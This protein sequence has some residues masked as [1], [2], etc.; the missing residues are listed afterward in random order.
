MSGTRITVIDCIMG[1]GK[2]SYAI[3]YVNS[4]PE[5]SF[6][7]CTPFLDEVQRIKEQC[8]NA[9]FYDPTCYNGRKIDD[10]NRLLMEGKNIVLTH[11]TFA[12]ADED[13]LEYISNTDYVLIMDETLNILENF[14]NVCSDSKQTVTKADIRML[15]DSGCIS[16]DDYGKVSW[17]GESYRGGKFSDAEKY[18]KNGT[19][20]YIDQSMFVW[21]FPASIFEA[22]KETF[23]LTYLFDGSILK[24]YLQYHSIPYEL[25]SVYQV[26][27]KYEI[28]EY[29]RDQAK[30]KSIKRLIQIYDNAKANDYRGTSLS[31]KWYSGNGEKLPTLKK[32]LHNFFQNK[33]RARA[34]DILWTCPKDY[35]KQLKGKGYIRVRKLTQ[36]ES[37]LPKTEKEKI[38]KKLSCFLSSNAKATN[39]YRERSV[40]AYCVNMFLNPYIK[41]YFKKKNLKDGTQIEVNEELFALSC[42]LQ[43]IFRSQ[44]REGKPITVYIPSVRMRTLLQRWLDLDF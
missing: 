20:L 36:E 8:L 11:A 26:E 35:Y 30:I 3:Q 22:F 38:E 32:H 40:L 1:S 23:V 42:M 31:K 10:F 2:T 7:Y 28:K 21:Q 43:W 9:H 6:V 34:H 27:G 41:K 12:N 39:D 44:V 14:N 4:H 29:D 17:T 19:L 25:K 18:A 15:M 13:T 33:M 16:V 37:V 24:P 5:Q